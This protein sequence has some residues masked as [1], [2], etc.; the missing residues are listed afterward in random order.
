MSSAPPN[1]GLKLTARGA[2]DSAPQLKPVFC[3]PMRAGAGGATMRRFLGHAVGM[4]CALAII[5]HVPRIMDGVV[6]AFV[7]LGLMAV[8]G[9]C[10]S[11]MGGL[12]EGGLHLA[13]NMAP[14][15]LGL[16]VIMEV[17][18]WLRRFYAAPMWVPPLVVTLGCPALLG[19]IAGLGAGSPWFIWEVGVVMGLPVALAFTAYWLPLQLSHRGA[20]GE[21]G[22]QNN[23]LQLTKPA[24]IDPSWW[25]AYER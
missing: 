11:G 9:G 12:G 22:P 7:G 18:L 6:C 13:W 3:G 21:S 20:R 25:T 8:Q 17:A 24:G 23:A 10:A 16:V 5:S 4:A 19:F 2:S 14:P 15:L 1:N